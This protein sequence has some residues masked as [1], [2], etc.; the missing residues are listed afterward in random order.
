M[1]LLPAEFWWKYN[2]LYP[3]QRIYSN[4]GQPPKFGKSDGEIPRVEAKQKK[5]PFDCE[6]HMQFIITVFDAHPQACAT[7]NIYLLSSLASLGFLYLISSRSAPSSLPSS[8][9]EMQQGWLNGHVGNVASLVSPTALHM[10]SRR[11]DIKE[12]SFLSLL[13]PPM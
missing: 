9:L 8:V 6:T 13:L 7:F 4:L 1:Q 12:H 5:K 2:G 11:S 10:G 3:Q